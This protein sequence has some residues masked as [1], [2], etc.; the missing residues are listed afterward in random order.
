MK[1]NRHPRYVG[2][3]YPWSKC[4]V[5]FKIWRHRLEHPRKRKVQVVPGDA[6]SKADCL[7]VGGSDIGGRVRG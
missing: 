7:S 2:I 5:C 6:R 4:T 3:R 1:C